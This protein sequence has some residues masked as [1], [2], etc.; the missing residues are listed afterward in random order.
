MTDIER[1][2]NTIK[3]CKNPVKIGIVIGKVIEAP[4]E[5]EKIKIA[6]EFKGETFIFDEFWSLCGSVFK[7]G[8][9]VAIQFSEN[10]QIIYVLGQPVFIAD[11]E[12]DE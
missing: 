12:D 4:P 2:A 10:N 3:N 6:V 5:D 1:L 8:D 9:K 7:K 11:K